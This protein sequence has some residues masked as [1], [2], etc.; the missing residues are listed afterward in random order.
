V[1]RHH[2]P[3]RLGIF[4]ASG[5]GK[6]EW[7]LRWLRKERAACRF[8]FDAEGEFA[9]A[10]GSYGAGTPAQM[11]EQMNSGWCI[12]D[13]APMFGG[14]WPAAFEYFCHFAFEASRTFRGR[15]LFIVDEVWRYT[16][17][18]NLSPAVENLVFTGRRQELDFVVI[19]QM[20]NRIHN[21]IRDS[22]TDVVCFALMDAGALEFPTD[23]GFD[24]E[25]L[26]RLPRFEWIRRDKSGTQTRSAHASPAGKRKTHRSSN[27]I[28]NGRE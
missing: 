14:N 23:Y 26:R 25:T 2:P 6:T 18:T 16:R 10:F 22:L 24:P 13:P 8:I 20:P 11:A 9:H 3:F 27:Q 21:A 12:F 19:G 5:Y 4:G 28:G 1:N 17:T 7:C 15:K